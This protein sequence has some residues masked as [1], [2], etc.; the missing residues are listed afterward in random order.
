MNPNKS[1]ID[2]LEKKFQAEMTLLLE[3]ST[4]LGICERIATRIIPMFQDHP[5]TSKLIDEWDQK[6]CDGSLLVRAYTELD[7]ACQQILHG[8]NI[9]PCWVEGAKE[10]LEEVCQE[11]SCSNI[12]DRD[13]EG[14]HRDANGKL[15]TVKIPRAQ[16]PCHR[17]YHKL[18]SLYVLAISKTWEITFAPSA[19][20]VI[21]ASSQGEMAISI[22]ANPRHIWRQLRVFEECWTIRNDILNIGWPR[23]NGSGVAMWIEADQNF[24]NALRCR[25]ASDFSFASHYGPD[26]KMDFFQPKVLIQLVERLLKEIILLLRQRAVGIKPKGPRAMKEEA[27]QLIKGVLEKKLLPLPAKERNKYT[28]DSLRPIIWKEAQQSS[29]H[30]LVEACSE[31]LINKACTLFA[32][33]HGW[34][35]KRGKKESAVS[36]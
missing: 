36:K 6:N 22:D 7:T 17:I 3:C 1:E 13:C 35:P 11:G 23:A 21:Q 5:L 19:Y 4:K 10:I 30:G 27:R 12:S 20:R 32:K 29:G 14:F 31:T 16:P 15:S 34:K 8:N 2:D 25:L 26:R 24:R 33:K 28:Y 18:Q 9:N